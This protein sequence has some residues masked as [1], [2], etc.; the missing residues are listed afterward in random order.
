[1]PPCPAPALLPPVTQ[2]CHA[3]TPCCAAQSVGIVHDTPLQPFFF[4]RGNIYIL[5]VDA[6]QEGLSACFC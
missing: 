4:F 2:Q 6:A 1:M 5:R 3:S